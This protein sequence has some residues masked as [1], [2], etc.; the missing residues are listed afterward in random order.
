MKIVAPKPFTFEGGKRA[1]LLLHGFTGNTADVRMLGRFLQKKGYTAHAPLYRG[2]G[3]EPEELVKYTAEDWWQDVLDGYNHLKDSGHEEIAAVGLSLGGIFSLKLGYSKPVKAVIP[4]C[5]PITPNYDRMSGGIR[6]F[7]QEYKSKV[8]KSEE[9][10]KEEMEAFEGTEEKTLK[11]LDKLIRDVR[12]HIDMIYAPTFV[13]QGRLDHM[14]DLD[15]AN[16]I[17]D[18]VEAH[19]K[20]LKW[21][22]E[23]GHAITLDKQRDEV[24]QDVYEFLEEL[25]WSE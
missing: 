3:V 21:Y 12:S 23:S 22:E 7:A 25:D 4:M 11:S 9:E 16:I 8:G 15:S 17:H 14:I 18:E 1:V 6:R 10:I 5:S 2:H 13:V 19:K 24:E 20:K